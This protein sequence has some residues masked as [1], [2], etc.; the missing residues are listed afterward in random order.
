MAEGLRGRVALVTGASRRRGIGTAIC[1]E[2]AADGADIYFTHWL[3]FDRTQPGGADP[4]APAALREELQAFGVRAEGVELDLSL[5]DTPERLLDEVTER[6]GPLSIL[7]N[8]AAYST[9]DGFER[10]DAETL[11]AHYAVNLR[12]V[13]LLSVGFARRYSGGP[14][15]RIVN[16]TSGQSLGPMP[17][18]LAYAATKGAIE[19]FTVTLAA[20]VGHKGI[21]VNAV[22]PGP[23]DTGWMTEELKRELAAK[24]PAG[25]V[26][27]PEDAAR[28]VAFLASDDAR[29]ITGQIIHSEGGFLRS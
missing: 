4:E 3:A 18:E 21:T 22:N 29:W 14:G 9:R 11:D 23:T 26:G 25:K 8:N 17:E 19:A 20:E 13:A 12:A 16:L 5:P 28:L 24:F 15:G 2:L 27:Q 10:L 7:V 1:R 6:L